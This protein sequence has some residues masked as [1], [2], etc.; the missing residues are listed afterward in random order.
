MIN[1]VLRL[2]R[3]NEFNYNKIKN[4][5]VPADGEICLVDTARDGLRA[6]CG[7]GKSTF[8][9]LSFLNDLIQKGYLNNG[10]F[11]RDTSFTQQLA[12]KTICVYI[13]LNNHQ[14]YHFNGSDYIEIGPKIPTASAEKP[15]VMKLYNGVGQNTDGTMTQKA[16]T[17]EL[18]TKVEL[19]LKEEEELVIF[20]F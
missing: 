17:D 16:I 11:Y 7:D 6:V 12:S 4:S 14:M 18:D 19:T 9:E 20:S 15:G 8:A 3:D 1:A 10:I 2:R 13:D 5:F